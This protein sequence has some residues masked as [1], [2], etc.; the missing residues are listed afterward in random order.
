MSFKL[1]I[2]YCALLGGWAAFLAWGLVQLTIRGHLSPIPYACLTGGIL[3][4]LVAG[5]IGAVDAALNAVGSQRII[6]VLICLG[7]GL[8]GGTVSALIGEFLHSFLHFPVV[9]GW[10]NP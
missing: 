7:I 8:V 2:Y 6:R 1:F 5:A 3:G 9:V 4:L 10:M